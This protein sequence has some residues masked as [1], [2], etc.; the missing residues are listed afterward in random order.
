[1]QCEDIVNDEYNVSIIKINTKI[2]DVGDIRLI[3]KI[4]ILIINILEC[5]LL[6]I[7]PIPWII[8]NKDNNIFDILNFTNN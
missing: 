5:W 7:Y 8:K 3:V 1:M 6:H 2:D 4:K